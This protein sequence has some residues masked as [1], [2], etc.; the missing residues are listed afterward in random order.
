MRKSHL[1][2]LSLR[3]NIDVRNLS[4]SAYERLSLLVSSGRYKQTLLFCALT[5]AHAQTHNPTWHTTPHTQPP[6]SQVGVANISVMQNSGKAA[7]SKER[8]CV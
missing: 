3:L 6:L 4:V 2:R 1:N 5:L 7:S 8:M